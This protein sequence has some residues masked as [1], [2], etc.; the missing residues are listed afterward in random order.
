MEANNIDYSFQS[1]TYSEIASELHKMGFTWYYVL[2]I[3]DTIEST[4]VHEMKNYLINN[5][6]SLAHAK[7]FFVIAEK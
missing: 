1:F 5:K 3:V 6:H 7:Y 4:D 2:S